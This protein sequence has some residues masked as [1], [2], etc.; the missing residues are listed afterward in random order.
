MCLLLPRPVGDGRR[1]TV[2]ASSDGSLRAAAVLSAALVAGLLAGYGVAVPVGAIGVLLVGFAARSSLRV[3]VSAALGVATVDGGYALAAVAG[4]SA[5]AGVVRQVA[6]PLRWV[7]AVAL[8]A[9]AIRT[10]VLALRR[11]APVALPDGRVYLAMVGLTALNPTTLV[12][13]AALV[14]GRPVGGVLADAV[15]VLAVFVASASWQLLLACGGRLLG[16]FV[17]TPR[18]RLVTASVGCLVILVLAVRLAW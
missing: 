1:A 9:V 16:R 7:A 2:G 10:G 4:G 11:V 12:Y 3:A 15:F 6:G 5:L 8:V 18:G 14:V 13:F 17:D